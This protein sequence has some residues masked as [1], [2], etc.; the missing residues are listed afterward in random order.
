MKMK[1]MST[2]IERHKMKL[3]FSIAL[4]GI[5]LLF[6]MTFFYPFYETN[7]DVGIL[8]LVSG[9][10]GFYD[11]HLVYS[12]IFF[13]M[14]LRKL[15]Q[16]S[17]EIPWYAW[18]QYFLLFCSFVSI[19]YVLLH[20]MKHGSSIW[21]ILI[22][23]FLFSYEGYVKLQY[24]KS[25]GI[26]T[27]AGFALIF[28]AFLQ[29]KV[30][31]PAVYAGLV[32][33]LSGSMYRLNQ[34]L[35]EA[36]LFTGLG[37]FFLFCLK[38]ISEKKYLR[39]FFLCVGTLL[40]LL[41]AV[42]AVWRVDR[43]A[44]AQEDWA[45]YLQYD[46]CRSQLLDYGFPDF[47]EHKEAYEKL[48][49][50]ETAYKLFRK[51]THQDSDKITVSVMESLIQLKRPKVIN[52][53]LI[54]RFFLTVPVR[55]LENYGFWCFGIIL[56]VWLIR[57]R[58]E[59]AHILT[60]LYEIMIVLL[61]YFFLFYRGRY[62]INRVDIGIW[63]SA[64]VVLMFLLDGS[65]PLFPVQS[66]AMLYAAAA[67]LLLTRAQGNLR[68]NKTDSDK[69]HQKEQQVLK[70]IREDTEHLYL[71]KNGTVSFAKAY[72]IWDTMPFDIGGNMYPLGGWTAQT[73]VYSNILKNYGV[74]NPFRDMIGNKKIYL[75]DNNIDMTMDYLH[76]WYS[77]DA[78]AVVVKKTGDYVV[79]Q[80]Q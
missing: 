45:Y 20:Q 1:T 2:W 75:I 39:R 66:G 28:Y 62:L 51:W 15:Y 13:G 17:H 16:F 8:S 44:Y 32:L 33:A 42:A 59:I 14:I 37:L 79:Y 40:L 9:V 38:D 36:A 7:D 47:T 34:F 26:L 48:G 54:K 78:Q 24:S 43:M 63:M 3:W 31:I 27:A 64:T 10:K 21:L 74:E 35:C 71:T 52:L 72:G 6:F 22:F 29:K 5:I 61:L 4:N 68:M 12:N 80:I 50:D 49:L 67:V 65:R 60:V 70:E 41:I 56:L 25:A 57:G 23:L 55:F 73:P 53:S 11:Y 46:D 76:R 18:M 69:K 30:V 19:T 77:K 58:H